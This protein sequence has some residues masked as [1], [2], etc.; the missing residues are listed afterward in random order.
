M[1]KLVLELENLTVETF[2]TQT[3]LEERGTVRGAESQPEGTCMEDTCSCG[4]SCV[5]CFDCSAV[6]YCVCYPDTGG[7]DPDFSQ[8]YTCPGSCWADSCYYTCPGHYC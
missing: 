2:E 7:G 8:P 3:P 6:S 1:K 4:G 5:T